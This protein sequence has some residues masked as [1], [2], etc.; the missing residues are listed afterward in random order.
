MNPIKGLLKKDYRISRSYF[1]IWFGAMLLALFIGIGISNYTNQPAG[2]F[3]VIFLVG[4][5]LVIFQPIMMLSLLNIEGKNQLW[6]YSPRSSYTLFLSKFA[7]ISIYQ[8]LLQ[9]VL[10]I[11]G[12]ISIYWY[13]KEVYEQLSVETF[14]ILVF[15]VNISVYLAGIYFACWIM[16]Y[17]TIYN[18]IKRS[19]TIK[20]YRWIIL[21]LIYFGY[22]IIEALLMQTEFVQNLIDLYVI[23]LT[24]NPLLNFEN[25][26]WNVMF[27]TVP[28]PIT[29]LI[30][31][32]VL[33]LLLF[34]ISTKLLER[35]VEV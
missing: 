29:P 15:L 27:E 5:T 6:L 31:C 3:F 13:G 9:L 23:D 26:Q 12:A 19:P 34:V 14:V 22:T 25:E 2:T 10:S 24:A 21:A 11:Y 1:L 18:T 30:Y 35:K 4:L 28:F 16:F 8:L 33:A 20:G 7:V 17:W 32:T